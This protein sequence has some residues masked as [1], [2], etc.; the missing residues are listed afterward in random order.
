VSQKASNQREPYD[1]VSGAIEDL[2]LGIDAVDAIK[3]ILSSRSPAR[4]LLHTHAAKAAIASGGCAP[5]ARLDSFLAQAHRASFANIAVEQ[6]ASKDFTK[7]WTAD[8]P[9]LC[10]TGDYGLDFSVS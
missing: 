1:R 7:V 8:K 5:V 10:Q 9:V 6:G 3:A 4:V 2:R